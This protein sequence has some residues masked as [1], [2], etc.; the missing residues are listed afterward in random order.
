MFQHGEHEGYLEHNAKYV[1][2]VSKSFIN[3]LKDRFRDPLTEVER[4]RGFLGLC[5]PIMFDS[6]GYRVL[7]AAIMYLHKSVVP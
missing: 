6:A 7:Y 1:E 5:K 3:Y 2:V 4:G